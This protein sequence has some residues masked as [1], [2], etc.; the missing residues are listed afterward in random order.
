VQS[1]GVVNGGTGSLRLNS[2]G[3]AAV[4]I[5]A[6]G[7]VTGYVQASGTGART[8]TI[9]GALAG[10]YDAGAGAN[11]A[12]DTITLG[13]TGSVL[14][15]TLGLGND[16]FTYQ[17]GAVNGII[18]AGAGTDAFISTL[19]AGNSATLLLS[20][21]S[22]F[23]TLTHTSGNLTL[24]GAAAAPAI[25]IIAGNGANSSMVTLTGTTG[26][27]GGIT[28]NGAILRAATVGALGT[29]AITMIDPTIQFGATGTYA[30]AINLAVLAPASADPTR[31]EA[32]A[33]VTA[34]LSGAI[35]RTGGDAAQYVTIGG[36]GVV[37]LTNTTN[38]WTG[39]TT[40]DAGATLQGA[41]GAISGSAIVDNG[42]LILNE[43]SAATLARG[44]S[45]TGTF[46]KIGA[47]NL[48][49]SGINSFTGATTVSAGTL[50]LTGG[51][52]L[53]DASAVTVASGATLNIGFSEAIGSLAGA[54]SVVL[55]G[56]ALTIGTDNSSTTFSGVISGA[57][58]AYAGSWNVSSGPNWT[59]QPTVFSGQGAAA[60]LFGGVASDYQIS[61]ISNNAAQINRLVFMDGYGNTSRLTTPVSDTLFADTGTP[62]Y[63]PGD[64]SAYVA[65]HV[66]T[67][68]NYAFRA[69]GDALIKDGTGTLTLSGANTFTGRTVINGG[70][71]QLLGGAA[72]ADGNAI[73]V[74]AGGQ[75]TVGASETIASIAGAGN[76][77]L[78]NAS[79][80][81]GNASGTLTGGVSGT[82]TLIITAGTETFGGALTN[83]GGLQV[84]AGANAVLQS[85]GSINVAAGAVQLGA[86][87]T[88]TNAGLIAAASGFGAYANGAN[89]SITNQASGDI[90]GNVGV[91]GL[92]PFTV[93]NAGDIVG[94]TSGI[95][96]NSASDVITN[97]GR[98]A[99]GTLAGNTITTSGSYGIQLVAGGTV[100]NN[101]GALISGNTAALRFQ[102]SGTLANTGTITGAGTGVQMLLGGTITNAS[103]AVIS[104]SSSIGLSSANASFITNGG[105]MNGT[106]QVINTGTLTLNNLAGG[107]IYSANSA[108][109]SSAGQLI[110]TNAGDIVGTSW[111]I[112]GRNVADSI[113]NNGRIASGTLAAGVITAGGS[114]GVLLISGG[115]LTNNAGAQIIG[116][117]NVVQFNATGTITNAGSIVANPAGT[118]T[119]VNLFGANSVVNNQAGGTI[120]GGRAV[121][122]NSAASNAILNNSGTIT[123]ITGTQGVLLFNNG[124][125]TNTATGSITGGVGIYLNGTTASTVVND[126]VIRGLSSS[127]I[128]AANGLATVT[129]SGSVYGA[130]NLN[131]VDLRRGGTITN[132]ATGLIQATDS[133]DAWGVLGYYTATI[134][135]AGTINGGAGIA[136]GLGTTSVTNSGTINGLREGILVIDG[137]TANITNTGTIYGA[138]Q[139]II[140]LTGT[141]NL[142]NQGTVRAGNLSDA[143]Y[144]KAGSVLN[145]GLMTAPVYSG[146][147]TLSAL[148]VVNAASGIFEGGTDANFGA[149][150]Q[151]GNAAGGNLTNYGIIR[152][153]AAG[154]IIGNGGTVTINLHAGSTTGRI[155]T[156]SGDDQITLFTGTGTGFAGVVDGASGITLQ[157][158]GTNAAATVGAI[159]LGGGANSVNL[160]GDGVGD[161]ATGAIGTVNLAAVANVGTLNKSETGTW[162]LTGAPSA[163]LTTINAGNGT[164]SGLLRFDGTGALAAAITVNGA[165]IRAES[166]GAFGTGLITLV[167]PTIQYGATGT[168][169]NAI[170]LAV[171]T[172]ASAD[173]STMMADAG[174]I[175][176]LTGAI[177]QS[178]AG[179]VDPVQ[180]LVISGL[181]TILL[182]NTANSW[183][184]TTTINNGATLQGASDT[185]SG[186]AII[187]N[188]TLAYV[189]PAS[190]TVVQAISGSGGVTV[191]G[192]AAGETLTF[193]GALTN[194]GVTVLDGSHIA[195][196]ATN[197]ITDV[198]L[199]LG[200]S[201]TVDVADGA[202]LSTTGANAIVSNGPGQTVNNLGV[203]NG[204]SVGVRLRGDSFINNGSATDA[205]ASI[206]GSAVG[207]A[208]TGLNS[209]T[210]YGLIKGNSGDGISAAN[211]IVSNFAGAQIIGGA[212][213]GITVNILNLINDGQ[214]VGQNN[215]IFANNL[216]TITNSGTIASGTVSGTTITTAGQDALYLRLGGTV[217]NQAGGIIAGQ[218]A[219][220]YVAGPNALTLN[221][222]GTINGNVAGAIYAQGAAAITNQ[223]SGVINGLGT[224]FG[225]FVAGA[226]TITNAG[227][228]DAST[229]SSA[230]A[231]VCLTNG[232]TVTNSGT[233]KGTGW[234]VTFGCSFL[235]FTGLPVSRSLDNQ[236][237]GTITGTTYNA[238]YIGNGSGASVLNAGTLIG[239]NAAIY[240]D[241]TN[242][243]ITNSGLIRVT[244]GTANTVISGIYLSAAGAN[245]TNSGT[246]ESTL[247]TGRGI[248]L[249]GGAGTITNLAGG[250]IS[251]GASGMAILLSGAGYTLDLRSGSTVT[252]LINAGQSTG[253]NTI[254]LAGTLDGDYAGGG[255]ADNVTLTDSAIVT[256]I[257]DG[258]AGIDA[259]IFDIATTSA[260]DMAQAINFESRVKTGAGILTL[261]GVD[262]QAADWTITA[263]T[264]AATGGSAINDGAGVTIAPAGTFALL[265][266][267][268]IRALGGF[269][270]VDLAGNSLTISGAD[271]NVYAG[272][273]GGT[274]NLLL[275]GTGSTTLTGANSYTGITFVD[276]GTLILGAND[277]LADA[278]SISVTDDAILDLGA[279]ADTV[280]T[281][282]LAGTLNGTG[283]LTAA[284][285]QLTGAT[286]N[287][288][289]GTGQLAQLGGTSTLNGT[290]AATDVQILGGTLALGGADRLADAAIV[291]V[292]SG[293]TLDLGAYADTVATLALAGTLNGTGTLT[294]ASYQLTGATVNANL[295]TGFVLNLGGTSTLN[296][297]AAGDVLVS[298]GTL[299]LGAAERLADT[300]L[301]EVANGATLNLGAFSET[302][303]QATLF[304]TLAGSGLLTAANYQLNGATIDA[305]L[306]AGAVTVLGGTTR[307]NGTSAAANLQIVSG[308]LMLGASDRLADAANVTIAS[309]ATLDLGA[310]V[311]TINQVVSAGTLNGT[312]TLT[313]GQ[314]L[315]TGATVNA[316]LGTGQL[317][318]LG[319][320][321]T[322]NG[323]AAATDVQILGGTLELGAADRL[324]DAAVVQVLSGATLDLGAYADTVA[325]LALA[326]TLNGTGTL[327]AGQ[328]L[329]T[330]ATVNANLGTGQLAQLGGTT[331]LN[332]TAAATDV[333]ILGGTLALGAADRL[334]NAA[335]VQ[336]LSGATLDLGAYADTVATLALAGTLNGTGTLTAASYQLTGATVNANLG[337]GQ[338][339]QLGGTS[340]LKGTAA[341]TDVQILGGTLALG[342][343]D[344]LA[345]AATMIVASGATF[346]MGGNAETVNRIISAGTINGTATLTAA[347]YQFEGGVV[348]ANLGTGTL[349][350][351]AGSTIL[352]GTSAASQVVLAGGT[353]VLGAAERLA[354]TASL[355]VLS[356]ATLDLGAFA[357]TVATAGI[358]GT[359]N[360]TG[361]LTAQTYDLAGGVANANLGTGT[362]FA[363]GAAVLNG[364]SGASRVEIANG[365]LTLGGNERIA[366]GAVV[367]IAANG[368]L[369]LAGNSEAIGTLFGAGAIT[370][371]AG[372]LTVD[373]SANSSYAGVISG[374]GGLTKA[375]SGLLELTGINTYTGPTLITGGN[376]A[377][378][379]SI[380]SAVTTSNGGILSGN[381]RVGGLTI[382]SG[383]ILA[384]GNS[385]GVM[386]VAGNLTFAAGSVYSVEVTPTAAD[387]TQVTGTVTLQGGTVQVLAANGV[388]N[389]LTR[390]TILTATGGVTGAFAGVTS[391]LA[392]LTPT[393]EYQVGRVDLALRRNDIAFVSVAQSPNQVSVATALQT[394]APGTA[395]FDSLLTQ[396]ATG[397]R[398]GFDALSGEIYASMGSSL[399]LEGRQLRNAFLTNGRAHGTGISIWANAVDSNGHFDSSF[400]NQTAALDTER[401]GVVGG[402]AWA[403]DAVAISV[404]GGASKGKYFQY[405]RNAS[406]QVDSNYVGGQAGYTTGA[407]TMQVGGSYSWHDVTTQRSVLFPGFANA[408]QSTNEGHTT[409]LFGELTYAL[410]ASET[411]RIEPYLG[412][413]HI[414]T[415]LN[416]VQETGGVAALSV[417]AI[418]RNVDMLHAGVRMAA[419][420]PVAGTG[421]V[422][423]PN[424]AI[425]LQH[426]F[427]DRNGFATASIGGS[428][429]YAILGANVPRDAMEIDAGVRI[430]FGAIDFGVSYDSTISA[431]QADKGAKLTLN[432]RF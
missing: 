119:A 348:N 154:A 52:A 18:N 72:I 285:Y 205:V 175:A 114:N 270:V 209:I 46:T 322:L 54:G 290:A 422:F 211:L 307:L 90:T 429:P 400:A 340:T 263:G 266:D 245:I 286:V 140:S 381:G 306:G 37:V 324:A 59:T 326:G 258:A 173:P 91:S 328:Y 408:L 51:A 349:V 319:G 132:T 372:R 317:A 105:T 375:G 7:T 1:G 88:L 282:A 261:S 296:G 338:L 232:G 404:G 379:G 143:A 207:I 17:G 223:A 35:K 238:A 133:L 401:T 166:A 246:I 84:N 407:L 10:N 321:T 382:G 95:V 30:N 82:G 79:L 355:A 366:N 383:G 50:T 89:A 253:T 156:G 101:A 287:A 347:N 27:T 22:A 135:N 220:V 351:A 432:I 144:L 176:T 21:V 396:S 77:L 201:A 131:G 269:G 359:L 116:A 387:L 428:A 236:A 73:L 31:F 320:T 243:S 237:G 203:I 431:E 182:T 41:S 194:A 13:A 370:L 117:A 267:E 93:T 49:L 384:P 389:P 298:G 390:Y 373:Q 8:V 302:V 333:Q 3:T 197:N 239:G 364:T 78:N 221:N 377:V 234:G 395:L 413:S 276:N 99:S 393:I 345:D 288:N 47:G 394:L 424:L 104:G 350:T 75:L 356:G 414:T 294:A 323:T 409:Q 311:D 28:V 427:G 292:A 106:L 181:G 411:G 358:A 200:T 416:A 273:I 174:V 283:T 97:S 242:A 24:S 120:S 354:D 127:G 342:A 68:I 233:I 213:N 36:A 231:G 352:N 151:F 265:S 293:A 199:L 224:G 80:T 188:G 4:T 67:Y 251:G 334:A 363:S 172:P 48:T 281:L 29:G 109:D 57:N 279:Y 335:V 178:S 206:T 318:Q 268:T 148:P 271:A 190:G 264:L 158:A 226:A 69:G 222:A 421:A 250:A 361:T 61:T 147:V 365:S 167:D 260:F 183:L 15:V 278:S 165:I 214:I 32:D 169:A 262:G 343:A 405:D 103:G 23:E 121:V 325:T 332:G 423:M 92:T 257:L 161:S 291:A 162:L 112:V 5:A 6:G 25:A 138:S 98:I 240:G 9:N 56:G 137:S 193:A 219:G 123:G 70:V 14:N 315:L 146:L 180:P 337:T 33:G 371:G 81:L 275:I 346:A 248:S 38:S 86:A 228:I 192:L 230:R 430:D 362:L 341:A 113:V 272:T 303:A 170:Q 187:A 142:V 295:G 309:G 418:D 259:L 155:T 44:I 11:T 134:T 184:G 126:G 284:S 218:R 45:G 357:E 397:A 399:L 145:A 412:Y 118:S 66:G 136:I 420:M 210:N 122:F 299:V 191:S 392:F 378:N 388:Y 227:L 196:T 150:I 376:L 425:G 308:T 179:G 100:T 186:S 177:T 34:T 189:Q 289:L 40:V 96:S 124:T 225:I 212:N 163:T 157:N 58:I 419:A 108:V 329:L 331:T 152:D 60:F 215:G 369:N 20:R 55:A 255:A 139:G 204:A 185:I 300:A 216:S 26:L 336:V 217:T 304:G 297:T 417:G 403:N 195:F 19:G 171:A 330:G 202:V 111:G 42:A 128:L 244:G 301:L 130:S 385:I 327:T 12:V 229:G 360:G 406:A 71:L 391:N 153:G 254:M 367:G 149:G 353:L 76:V 241:G 249:A 107:I 305:N 62:G 256:G 410:L 380:A 87:A 160:R 313:A 415:S 125:I 85:T 316:N 110:V 426:G 129:N 402:F 374:S 310:F 115:T 141:V 312:G 168:F 43:A 235:P 339:A 208:T 274:G 74:N 277:V 83:S 94:S 16:Q 314:Y 65:D 252:G 198:V 102:Q 64:F 398:T 344:R 39:L 63:S 2:A 280:A 386:N 164:P 368:T 159:D 53:A 247:A